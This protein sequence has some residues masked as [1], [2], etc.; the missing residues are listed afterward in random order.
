MNVST[1][2]VVLLASMVAAALLV[3][4]EQGASVV[5]GDPS[6]DIAEVDSPRLAG[7][8]LA[9]FAK[10]LGS[11]PV[12]GRLVV[13]VL[14]ASNRFYLVDKLAAQVD[15]APLLYPLHHPSA[16][17]VAAHAALALEAKPVVFAHPQAEHLPFHFPTSQDYVAAYLAGTTT[18][19]EIARAFIAKVKASNAAV[20]P[21]RAV[22]S[23]NETDLLAQAAAATQ[24]YKDK[25][26]LS[27]LDGVPIVV[28]EEFRV[29]GYGTTWGTSFLAQHAGGAGVVD[30]VS[31]EATPVQ[32]MRAAGALIAGKTNMQE[33]GLGV[34]GHNPHFGVPR[35]PY[36]TDHYSS[37]SSSGSAVAVAAGLVPIALGVD[38]GGSIRLPAASN[39]I[40]GLKATFARISS[41]NN[42]LVLDWTVGH[43][44]PLAASVAD[45]ALAYQ[46]LAGPDPA[47]KLT[48]VQPAVH[49]AQLDQLDDLKGVRIGVYEAWNKHAQEDVVKAVDLALATL[50]A[51]G[52][53]VVP[54]NIPNLGV[55]NMAHTLTILSEMAS[56]V[57]PYIKN[58]TGDFA[59]ETQVNLAGIATSVN[60]Y[61]YIN[62]QR[63]RAHFMDL[64]HDDIFVGQK[65]D[66][67]V[68]PSSAMTIPNIPADAVDQGETNLVNT[69]SIMRFA[70]L[71]N[72]LG[73]PAI[74]VP[75]GYS[76]AHSTNQSKPLPIGVQ[77][78]AN[79][80]NE[81]VV[82]RLGAVLEYDS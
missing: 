73:L 52:A 64:L 54:I 7:W 46:I 20:P 65:I 61:E 56:S 82:L 25:A 29:Y 23:I 47:D 62:A 17:E 53:T 31:K 76:A 68:S 11:T 19:L 9:V 8:G 63:L 21:L 44:G 41:Q 2:V 77:V 72:F 18:P 50:T 28:K 79:H 10:L 71:G 45:A 14:M 78:M 24:R 32:R 58:H 27:L 75:F 16:E 74:S 3:D 67:I 30:S 37:G 36:N 55:A 5:L 51:R 48:L 33:L 38:G 39:G 81:H 6:Y 26:P 59:Y 57:G 69:A 12:L 43:P 22:V 34:T 60:A 35:N 42:G 80:W 66:A 1:V 70:Q 49:V 13:R 4:L 15:D 40:V